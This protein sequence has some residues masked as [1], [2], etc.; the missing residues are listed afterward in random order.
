[1][2]AATATPEAGSNEQSSKLHVNSESKDNL[3]DASAGEG[4][5]V[6][7]VLINGDIDSENG[8]EKLSSAKQE[9]E[10]LEISNENSS[11]A[12]PETEYKPEGQETSKTISNSAGVDDCETG[13][14]N[15]K[16]L[17]LVIWI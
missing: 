11:D 16:N 10:L 15:E 14:G 7:G 17:A 9:S 3:E 5:L 6:E 4:G 2:S 8:Q 13:T 12:V 1:M